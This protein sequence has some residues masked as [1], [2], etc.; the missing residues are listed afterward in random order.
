M[1]VPS[2]TTVTGLALATLLFI[3][4]PAMAI[5]AQDNPGVQRV[6]MDLGDYR[7]HPDTV[8]IVAG[9][10]AELILTNRDSITPHNFIVEAPEAGLEVN[11]QVPAGE[12]VTVVLRP[13][14]PGTYAFYCDKQLLFFESH[15][16]KGME[17]Q[18]E[19]TAGSE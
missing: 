19:V 12:S 9:T 18:I 3:L 10:S 15:R 5:A 17:G 6:D 11:L 8:S 14:R 1:Y 2:W 13:T 7:F 4:T 16:E